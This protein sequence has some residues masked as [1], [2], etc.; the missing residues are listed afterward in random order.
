[1]RALRLRLR[2]DG[3]A[4]MVDAAFACWRSAANSAASSVV[5]PARCAIPDARD[6]L[7]FPP[8]NHQPRAV[9]EVLY[10]FYH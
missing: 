9:Y 1:M 5:D 4:D 6:R 10:F 3:G 7:F 2:R 8:A